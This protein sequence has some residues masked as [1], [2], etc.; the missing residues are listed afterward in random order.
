MKI[1]RKLVL[2]MRTGQVLYED[3]Y[4]HEGEIA[5]CKGGGGTSTTSAEPWSGQQPYLSD[6]YGQAQAQYEA[7]MEYY[8]GQTTAGFQPEQEA[9]M[10]LT[11]QRALMGNPL[12]PQAQGVMSDTLAGKYMDP[13][14]NPWLAET[15]NQ[16]AGG[17]SRQFQEA[18]MPE[19]RRQAMAAGAYGGERQG[20]A[21]GI[22]GRGLAD[23]M[24]NLATGIYAPA[25]QQERGFQQQAMTQAPGLAEAD[26]TDIGK[27]AAVG[28]ERQAMEQSLID[29]ALKKWQ[30]SQEEPWQRLGM[31]SNLITGNAGGTSSSSMPGGK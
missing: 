29:E 20:V 27:L 19:I 30:F 14:S 28:E 24:S 26:Y 7:P 11:T 18:T 22:A 15:Y 5:K 13:S 3:S 23:S 10:G 4:D 6:V 21:E 12:L 16:A 1:Y 25:Y 17:L 8:P 2:E 9:A 31:Y